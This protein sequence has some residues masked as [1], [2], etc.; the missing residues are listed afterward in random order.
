MNQ[1]FSFKRYVWMLKRQWY[2]NAASYK[3]GILLMVLVPDIL[4]WI[5]NSWKITHIPNPDLGVANAMITRTLFLY[6]FSAL[7]FGFFDSKHKKMSYFSL[8]VSV[9]ERVAVAFTYVVILAPVLFKG[10]TIVFNFVSVQL[11]DHIHG[12]SLQAYFKSDFKLEFYVMFFNVALCCIF[13][14]G[15]LI[16]GKKGQ[17]ITLFTIL[18]F[19][20]FIYGKLLIWFMKIGIFNIYNDPEDILY[21]IFPLCWIAMYFVM[22]RKEA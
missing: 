3:W 21:Y 6:V 10:I 5:T 15:S 9:L 13:V 16:F 4:F 14:L 22:K 20:F 19:L 11:F 1:I 2:E 12:T 17:V 7:F 18:V 8:P